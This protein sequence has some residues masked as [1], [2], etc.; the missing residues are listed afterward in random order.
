MQMPMMPNTAQ[1]APTPPFNGTQ[2]IPTP[3]QGSAE[4]QYTPEDALRRGTLFPDLDLPFMNV[5][6][7]STPY[8]GTP[9]GELMAICFTVNELTLYLD[10]HTQDTEAFA[11]LRK[12][13]RLKKEAHDR[14]VARF[15]ALH[16]DDMMNENTFTWY[17]SPWP[18]ETM[19]RTAN[20]RGM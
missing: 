1:P 6:N 9:L 16:I 11:L 5:G 12:L 14:Y 13:L 3:W 15:G 17:K 4:P 10:T 8:D 20:E 19:P 18:W 2:L 7:V